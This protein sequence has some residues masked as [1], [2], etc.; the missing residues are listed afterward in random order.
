MNISRSSGL[1]HPWDDESHIMVAQRKSKSGT[2]MYCLCST[3]ATH[4]MGIKFG[5]PYQLP[6]HPIGPVIARS[7][8]LTGSALS[9]KIIPSK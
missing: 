5:L 3:F 8:L 9:L 4:H 6:M 7:T 2:M 1:L